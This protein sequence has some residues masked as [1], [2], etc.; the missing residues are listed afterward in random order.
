MLVTLCLLF[1]AAV[2]PQPVAGFDIDILSG[3]PRDYKLQYL[4]A[5]IRKFSSKYIGKDSKVEVGKYNSSL[6]IL[7]GTLHILKDLP[8]QTT[9]EFEALRKENNNAYTSGPFKTPKMSLC[10][11]LEQK[12]QFAGTITKFGNA[13]KAC[14]I[15]AG[16]YHVINGWIDENDFPP[17]P[18]SIPEW[19]ADVTVKINKTV[20]L[21]MSIY[22]RIE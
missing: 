4:D 14:P 20:L 13:P 6:A 2:R 15:R 17:M 19:R 12:P 16:V 22:I 1:G 10:N 9:V 18:K 21:K 3:V 5:E 7:N 8:P 11:F